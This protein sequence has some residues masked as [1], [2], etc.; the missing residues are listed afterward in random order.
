MIDDLSKHLTDQEFFTYAKFFDLVICKK[1]LSGE[2]LR[3][4]S[5]YQFSIGEDESYRRFSRLF[6]F[7]RY[8][9]LPVKV[10]DSRYNKLEELID[11]YSKGK[12]IKEK[13]RPTKEDLDK[14][15]QKLKDGKTIKFTET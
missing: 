15:S 1:G 2:D 5:V 7:T 10:S 13:G 9:D 4:I 8:Q 6:N 14:I 3:E 12:D 11:S